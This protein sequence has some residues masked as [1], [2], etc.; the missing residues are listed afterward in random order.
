M[1]NSRAMSLSNVYF[2]HRFVCQASKYGYIVLDLQGSEGIPPKNPFCQ[3]I[4][5]QNKNKPKQKGSMRCK[6]KISEGP[7]V[8]KMTQGLARQRAVHFCAN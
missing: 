8:T 1:E 2:E 3:N 6:K 5:L 7:K 4:L